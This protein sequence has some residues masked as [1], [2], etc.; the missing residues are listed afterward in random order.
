M[1]TFTKLREMMASNKDLREKLERIEK[2]YDN[3]F[4][5]VFSVIKRLLADDEQPKKRIG[6]D[7]EN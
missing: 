7:A 5:V 3:R 6:F 2:K 4:K 1:R